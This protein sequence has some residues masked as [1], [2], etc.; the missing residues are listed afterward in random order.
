MFPAKETGVS[1]RGNG[2][3][4][5]RKRKFPSMETGREPKRVGYLYLLIK[6][7]SG[8]SRFIPFFARCKEKT[9]MFDE[10]SLIERFAAGSHDAFER[11]FLRYHQKVYYFVL[12]LVK[13]EAEAEDLT[14]DIFLKVWTNRSRFAEVKVFGSY[15]YVLAKY[16]VLNHIEARRVDLEELDAARNVESGKEEIPHEVL[17]AKDLRL[18]IDM[19]VDA[20]PPQRKSVFRMSRSEGLTNAEIAERL[21]LSKRTVEN[22]LNLALKELRNAM[23]LLAVCYVLLMF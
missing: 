6:K 2:R 21:G 19:I 14:Q 7:K 18:M 5:I 11:L 17:I 4:L 12:G 10:K 9:E 15:L 8:L 23:F 1:Y 22:H 3:S 16:T 13:S 20:M